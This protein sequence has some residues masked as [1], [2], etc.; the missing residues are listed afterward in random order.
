MFTQAIIRS[1]L[2][3]LAFTSITTTMATSISSLG[4]TSKEMA[5]IETTTQT[6]WP[7][8]TFDVDQELILTLLP[9]GKNASTDGS[10]VPNIWTAQFK[11]TVIR[12]DTIVCQLNVTDTEGCELQIDNE[13]TLIEFVYGNE[14]LLMKRQWAFKPEMNAL[15]SLEATNYKECA[16]TCHHV[17]GGPENSAVN[18]Y[19]CYEYLGVG[20]G[21]AV[22]FAM[23]DANRG[24]TV[25]L[26][27][28]SSRLAD[29][30]FM[31]VNPRGGN[32]ANF[33]TSPT[34]AATMGCAA[35][36]VSFF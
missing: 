11:T 25:V 5:P 22:P 23:A 28:Y 4:E 36:A 20:V 34:V 30:E 35:V 6:Y 10:G 27:P 24:A 9:P 13:Y 26:D 3:A 32:S 29:D 2:T 8:P 14:G 18:C 16:T 33:L 31:P 7:G 19:A 17:F 21:W 15:V 12:N 1:V